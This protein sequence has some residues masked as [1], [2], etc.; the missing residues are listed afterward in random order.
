M[1]FLDKVPPQEGDCRVGRVSSSSKTYPPIPRSDSK[2]AAWRT[3][4]YTKTQQQWKTTRVVLSPSSLR[5]L[6]SDSA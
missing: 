2:S 1:P 5:C 3:Q 6:F 4:D